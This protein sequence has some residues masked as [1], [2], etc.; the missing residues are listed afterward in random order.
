MPA[1]GWFAPGIFY[2][3]TLQTRISPVT[4]VSF[5]LQGN[6][7]ELLRQGESN[8]RRNSQSDKY[9]QGWLIMKHSREYPGRAIRASLAVAF[10][11]M[12]GWAASS[13]VE[14]AAAANRVPHSHR[15]QCDLLQHHSGAR[16]ADSDGSVYSEIRREQLISAWT[17]PQC[18]RTW[19]AA[20][21][22]GND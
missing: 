8:Q 4:M 10:L 9:R 17:S 3:P 7:L 6:G 12:A 18:R 15:S 2:R 21:L 1:G 20:G 16:A 22:P 19:G 11:S 14:S 5:S 13:H